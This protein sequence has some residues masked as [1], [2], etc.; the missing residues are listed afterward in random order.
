MSDT[1][2][3]VALT[4]SQEEMLNFL[5]DATEEYPLPLETAFDLGNPNHR[6]TLYKEYLDLSREGYVKGDKRG[7]WITNRNLIEQTLRQSL[8]SRPKG[9]IESIADGISGKH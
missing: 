3:V 4:K 2:E 6:T 8:P 5:R 9:F 7:H 1:K